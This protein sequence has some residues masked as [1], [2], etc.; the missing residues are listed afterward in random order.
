MYKTMKEYLDKLVTI[1]NLDLDKQ[2]I[3]E[4]EN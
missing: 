1:Y 3:I 2:I 4:T